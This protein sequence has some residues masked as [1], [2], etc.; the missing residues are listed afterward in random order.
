[1]SI[2]KLY[3][4]LQGEVVGL[5]GAVSF[6]LAKIDTYIEDKSI[7]GNVIQD[8]LGSF[9]KN[10]S[11]SYDLPSNSQKFP[12]FLLD[13][14]KS[15][16][17]VK[18]FTNSP[19]F[20]IA[21]FHAYCRSLAKYPYRINSDYLIFKYSLDG[22]KIKIENVWLKKVWEICGGSQR[23]PI[24]LQWKQNQIYNIRPITWYSENTIYPPFASKIDFIN[25]IEIV[26]NMS[27]I[28]GEWRKDW[29]KNLLENI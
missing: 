4:L 12:D 26:L 6:T 14:Q 21:N 29:K 22:Y 11:I 15:L 20:D 17:E 9:M 8:W 19:N 13:N 2:N 7:V 27:S 28:G 18:C 25:A 16:L 23:S 5:S 24:K 3:T 10:K 1:M